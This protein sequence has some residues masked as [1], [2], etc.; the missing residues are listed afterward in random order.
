MAPLLK[1]GELL[2]EGADGRLVVISEGADRSLVVV[3]LFLEVR[4]AVLQLAVLSK[5][6]V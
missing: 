5:T 3:A 4:L 6:G 2:P 1:G